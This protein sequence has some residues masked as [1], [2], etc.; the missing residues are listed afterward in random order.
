MWKSFRIAIKTIKTHFM[1][2]N[3]ILK[4]GS[5]FLAIT[6]LSGCH[7]PSS[8]PKPDPQIFENTS[9]I[10]L[11]SVEIQFQL[12]LPQPTTSTEKFIVE[13]LD[14]VTG[15]PYNSTEIEL[16]ALSNQIFITNLAAPAGS[17][18][19][20]RYIKI[21]QTNIPEA[22]T[23]GQP[24][25]YRML[26]AP[27]NIIV[28]DVLQAWQG[29]PSTNT[30]GV[31]RGTVIEQDS[32][33]PI[34]DILICAGGK[35][36]FTDSNGKYLLEGLSPGIHNVVFYAMDGKYRTYQQ[37]AALQPG[38]TTPADVK[39]DRMPEVEVTFLV[40]QPNDALGAPIYMAGNVLQ[41]GNTF[42]DLNGGMSIKP[43]RMPVLDP[44]GDGTLS[45]T[46]QL[47]AEMDLRYKFTLGDG[48]WNAE[49][50]PSDGFRIR[51]LIVPTEDVTI[52]HTIETWRSAGVGPITFSISI[53]PNTSP[54]DDKFIQF[55]TDEWTEPLPLWPL[56]NGQYL[57]IL[58]SPITRDQPINY[59]F[60][61]Q[62]ACTRAS[63]SASLNSD[64]QVLP[65]ENEQTISLTLDSWQNWS[66]RQKG[67]AIQDAY[68]P[69]KPPNYGT[70]VELTPEMDPSWL[71]QAA[72][73]IATIEEIGADT[74]I[75]SPQWLVMPGSPYLHPQLGLTPSF[76]DLLSLLGAAQ[77]QGLSTGLF[78]QIGPYDLIEEFWLSK[79]H[80]DAWWQEFFS[81]Y[82]N[83]LINYANIAELSG[84]RVLIIG[85][86]HLLPAFEDGSLPDG[87]ETDVPFAFDNRWM[88]LLAEIREVYT[89]EIIWATHINQ[90]MDPLPNFVY[91]FD[92]IYI[93]VDSPLV[94][95][96]EPSF[97][98]IQAGF[99]EII[100][101]QIY[102]VYRSYMQPITLAIA[103]PSVQAGASGC[104]LVSDIC[105]NDGLFRPEQLTD[106]PVNLDQQALIYNAIL[107]VVASRNWITSVS[108]RGF[109][110]TVVVHDGASSVAGKPASDVIM[111]WFSNMKP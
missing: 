11:N 9:D 15:L 17:V 95:D 30:T 68:I 98:A 81:T 67:E 57:F 103:Y 56:G 83:F 90:Q 4:V 111:Y 60:C 76:D 84:T 19:K 88:E 32:Q 62:A 96:D 39:L 66:I 79:H 86:K 33:Q 87:T 27:R 91:A 61:R 25:A 53:P 6:M 16:K 104:V 107:P 59:R 2:N 5:L 72:Q 77:S 52:N 109:E 100:D 36:T 13:I 3:R 51:Q 64:R 94:L 89:G 85:G 97:D 58:Y 55:Q 28:E 110:P 63:D 47:Y 7:F 14:E 105:F 71:V 24:I 20:Y 22:T 1:R 35:R 54:N 102:E 37:G 49:Q 38:M 34:P 65:S 108:I 93:S 18:I 42:A 73:G 46:L 44:I 75:F 99:T 31:L 21:D 101:R 106:Y 8:S 69:I 70:F 45:I 12:A 10:A 40:S 29:E 26:Y 23:D 74:A 43:K 82:R 92:G 80:T 50:H 41:L 48:Y 78:P